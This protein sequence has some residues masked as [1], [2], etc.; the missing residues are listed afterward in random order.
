MKRSWERPAILLLLLAAALT[1]LV[2]GVAIGPVSVPFF[3]AISAAFS[4]APD[5]ADSQYN[6]WLIIR[7]IRL[8]RVLLGF[9][10]G[11]ALAVSGTAMQGLFR[12]PL[13]SPYILGIAS[14]AS[15]GAALSIAL[16]WPAIPW[17]PVGAFVGAITATSIVYGLARGRGR[18]SIFTLI[19]GGVAVG[20]LFSAVTSLLIF[21]AS[22]GERMADVVFW[23]MGGLGRANWT[24]VTILG[25]IF[26]AGT[27]GIIALSRD[28]NALS[29]GDEG[30]YHVGTNPERTARLLL[31]L[32]TLLTA[33]AVSLSGTIGFVGLI[34]PHGLRLLIGS[35]HRLLVPASALGGGLF[36]VTADIVA[37]VVMRPIELPVGILT[38]FVGAPFFLILLATQRRRLG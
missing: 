8:P 13:G 23:I 1:V 27:A 6:I 37:R 25:P 28:L 3:Q 22:R 24:S 17:L 10:V 30:A 26:A 21:L 4:S 19:L 9:F 18:T 34:V 31:L 15:A 5:T 2:A 32:T 16:D 29:L 12:N 35:D 11:G 7:Q 33:A 14:G 38:A 36:L 20:A